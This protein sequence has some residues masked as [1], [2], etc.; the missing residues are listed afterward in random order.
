MELLNTLYNLMGLVFVLGTIA[1]MG[2][3]LTIAQITGPLRNARFVIVALLANFIIPPIAALLLI[4]I[5]SLEEPLAAGL[6]LVSLAAGAPGLPKTAVFAK[7]D[8]A[9]ATGLMVLL[10]V[11]TIIILPI[12]LPLLLTGIS[13]TFWD[14]ASGLVY[15]ILVPLA[16]SLFVRARYPEAAASAQPLFAQASNISLL[17]LMVLMVVLNFSD[18]VNLLGSGGLLASLILVILTVAGGY[19][20]GSLGKAEGWIQA[21]GSGQRNI[22]AA[23]VVATLNFGNDEVVMVVV[24]SLIVL[25]VLIPLALELGKRRAMAE[26]IKEKSEPEPKKA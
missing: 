13:V 7:V 22:A 24:Y 8:T 21:L 23:M 12:A 18:V 26:E 19:L 6:L 15:L 10:V 9:A 16:L 17:I 5:F 25:V 14:V 3:S 4:N 20:L 11:V 1:S 2:L